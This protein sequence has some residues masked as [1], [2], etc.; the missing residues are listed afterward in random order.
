MQTIVKDVKDLTRYQYDYCYDAN[1]GEAGY[2]QDTLID[3]RE[4][5]WC[6]G[7]AILLKK[8]HFVGWTLLTP[9][10]TQRHHLLEVTR[11]V[12]GKSKVTAQFW[13]NEKDRRKGYGT[14]LMNEVKKIDPRPHVFPHDDS[15]G[16]LFSK[17]DVSVLREDSKYIKRKDKVS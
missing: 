12:K 5:P 10:T 2:M 15:S 3:C 17:F 9:V 6:Q 13:V 4:L 16:E 7:T 8:R 14:M 11:Y 1:F